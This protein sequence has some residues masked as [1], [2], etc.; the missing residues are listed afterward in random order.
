MNSPLGRLQ[1]STPPTYQDKLADLIR[2]EKPNIVVE[3]GVWEGLS[4]EY[5]LKALDDNGRGRLWS[6]DPMDKDQQF[7]GVQGKP[8]LFY[9]HPIVHPRFSLIRE[10]SQAALKPLFEEVGPFDFFLHDSDHDAACQV[11]EFEAAWEY[12]RPGGI[13]ASDDVFWGQPPHRSWD[14]FLARHGIA[15]RHIIGNAQYVRRP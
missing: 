5:I 8:E 13:I 7:N 3:T 1:L 14:K 9:D 12:V 10:Y 6:I 2:Q 11:F 4:A 15:E